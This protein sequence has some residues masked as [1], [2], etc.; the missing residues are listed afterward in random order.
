LFTDTTF[1]P[2]RY[3]REWL[4]SSLSEFFETGLLTDILFAVRGGKEA[5]VYCCRAGP[6]AGGRLLAAKVYRPRKYRNL[7]NDATYRV[8]RQILDHS[9]K[10]MRANNQ[11]LHRA[12]RNRTRV[13]KRMR[14]T[15][16]LMHE[17]RTMRKLHGSGGDLPA[18][19]DA[20]A[21][22]ILMQFIGDLD[23]AAPTLNRARIEPSGAD[24]LL[25]E[26]LGNV[27]TLLRHG[28]VHADLSPYNLM[29]HQDRC[30]LID[31]PQAVDVYDNPNAQRL[32]ERDVARVWKWFRKRGATASC[33]EDLVDD[34]W[35]RVFGSD[36]GVPLVAISDP[37]PPSPIYR[38]E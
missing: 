18:P 24:R 5:S 15:S 35:D 25:A 14:H 27:E 29:Y 31:F 37:P 23:G 6:S 19:V 21:N 16:W 12:V 34:I 8:G 30:W 38:P 26:V 10:A 20:G 1:V 2:G 9:G 17:Y 7:R 32:L 11:R 4:H 22:V 36:D 28:L 3:E 13:G 33:W